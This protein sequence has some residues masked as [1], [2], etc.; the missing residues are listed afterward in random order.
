MVGTIEEAVEKLKKWLRLRQSPEPHKNV[1]ISGNKVMMEL[2]IHRIHLNLSLRPP[3]RLL[4]SEAVAMVVVPGTEGDFGIC[5]SRPHV[6]SVRNGVIEI[7]SPDKPIR[8]SLLVALQRL[9]IHD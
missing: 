6:V 5:L 3:E 7:H 9:Q 4:V 8:R 1:H 2:L